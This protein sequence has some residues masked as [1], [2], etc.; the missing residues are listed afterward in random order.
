MGANHHAVNEKSASDTC[1]G[2]LW[3]RHPEEDHSSQHE[4]YA[5]Q[6]ADESDQHAANERLAQEKVR[7]QDLKKS[8]HT[9][10]NSEPRSPCHSEPQAKNL[11]FR[12][13]PS[14][15]GTQ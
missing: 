1:R 11:A 15:S 8:V 12:R 3:Q 14:L 2:K 6:R 5:N 10:M 13:D 7:T 4:V 9:S